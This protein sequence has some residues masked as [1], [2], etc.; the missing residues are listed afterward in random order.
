MAY[1]DLHIHSYYSD[2]TMSPKE[3]LAEGVEK[4]LKVIAIT[5]HNML[6]GSRELVDLCKNKD[7]DCISGVELDAVE[8]GINYHILGYGIG[9]DNIILNERVG[10]NNQKLEEVNIKLIE[11]MQIDYPTILVEDYQNY[12]YNHK[13]GGWKALHYF[14]HKGLSKSLGDGFLFYANYNISNTCVNFPN[15][16]TVCQWIHDAGGHSVLAHPGKVLKYSKAAEFEKQLRYLYNS[17]LDGIECYYPTHT[18]HIQDICV[19]FC[20]KHELIITS[21]S[22]CHGTFEKSKIGQLCTPIDLVDIDKLK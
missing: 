6:Q 13:L 18:K 8:D 14:I 9:L 22:D 21:G 16:K 1:V 17:G 5:D 11:K 20:K 7:I 3:I 12:S 4:K 2:G 15:V 10:I 19:Q